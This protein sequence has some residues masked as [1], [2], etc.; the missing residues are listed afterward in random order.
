MKEDSC[1]PTASHPR[2]NVVFVITPIFHAIYPLSYHI[3]REFTP[4]QD[5]YFIQ[6]VAQTESVPCKRMTAKLKIVQTQSESL[7]KPLSSIN[8]RG[9]ARLLIKGTPSVSTLC[10]S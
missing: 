2:H 9:G 3:S 8:T 7:L 4:S 5:K 1:G 6:T 10:P